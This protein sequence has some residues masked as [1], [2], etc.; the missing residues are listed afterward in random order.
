MITYVFPGQGSQQ[1]GM[2]KELFDK[3]EELVSQA[4]DILGYSIEEICLEDPDLKLI[5]QYT[6]PALY[7]VNALK[8]LQ[9]IETADKK[10]DYVAGHS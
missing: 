2:G 5:T 4:D 1:K 9:R 7:V 6:Q 8:Y 10:P 3:Y